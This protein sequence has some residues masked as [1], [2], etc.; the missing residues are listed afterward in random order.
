MD[1]KRAWVGLLVTLVSTTGT[2]Q[3]RP[4]SEEGSSRSF[5]AMFAPAALP[6][7]TTS[8]YGF[9]GV[10]QIGAGFRQGFGVLELEGRVEFDYFA[11]SVAPVVFARVPVMTSGPYQVAPSLGVGMAFN[12]GSRYID[13]DNFAYSAV[14]LVPGAALSWRVAETASLLGEVSFPLDLTFSPGGGYRFRPLV[15]GGA[16]LYLGQEMTAGALARVGAETLREPGAFSDTRFAF[17]LWVG[18]GYRFF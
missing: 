11:L 17:S 4:A 3:S 7:G 12:S 2:A 5:G 14:R 9:A 18:L 1:E 15:G 13:T 8:A 6:S 10:P 16:E